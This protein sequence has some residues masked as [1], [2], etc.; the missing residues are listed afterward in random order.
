MSVNVY[1]RLLWDLVLGVVMK[2]K[3]ENS[4]RRRRRRTEP[5]GRRRRVRSKKKQRE[6][7]CA[8]AMR[9]V[10][11][12][13]DSASITFSL[14]ALSLYP[15]F[16]LSCYQSIN[17]RRTY[18]QQEKRESSWSS[19]LFVRPFIYPFFAVCP[20]QLSCC[21]YVC[22]CTCVYTFLTSSFSLL[23]VCACIHSCWWPKGCSEVNFALARFFCMSCSFSDAV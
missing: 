23:C 17:A 20:L 5:S 10:L 2:K 6:R 9:W 21:A 16:T 7:I 12:W 11:P 19:H 1:A 3:N 22:A 18:I 4:Q 15:S 14:T 8:A 13:R